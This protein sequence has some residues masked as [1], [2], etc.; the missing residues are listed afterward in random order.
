M[1]SCGPDQDKPSNPDVVVKDDGNTTITKEDKT[2]PAYT[3][4][5]LPLP[6]ACS[7]VSR[8]EVATILGVPAEDLEIKDGSGS[9]NH[10][11][12]CFF[13]WIGNRPNAG[14]LIQVQKNP[15]GDEFPTW[16]TSFV[17]SKRTMGESDFSG[18]DENFKY[19]KLEGL[20]DDGSYSYDLGKYFWRVGD[21]Y[22]YMVAF[23][24]DMSASKQ[25][26]AA[27]KLGAVVMKNAH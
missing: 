27:K 26:S 2:K 23:N 9:S 13:K 12:A 4:S 18:G 6:D 7:L 22:V 24:E 25:L 15:V 10:A 3:P 14:I 21:D 16:A 5:N 19:D 8:N 17:E 11:R 20:G 1:A